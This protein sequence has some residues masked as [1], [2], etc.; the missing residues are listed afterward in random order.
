MNKTGNLWTTNRLKKRYEKFTVHTTGAKVQQIV[1]CT[2][3]ERGVYVC[4]LEKNKSDG[5]QI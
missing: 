4:R 1:A 2:Q 5:E 3:V